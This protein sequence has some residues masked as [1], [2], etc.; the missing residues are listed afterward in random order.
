M[1]GH[2]DIQESEAGL[3]QFGHSKDD[4][5][6]RQIKLYILG[7]RKARISLMGNYACS[8]RLRLAMIAEEAG[9]LAITDD[10]RRILDIEPT[11]LHQRVPLIIGS[12]DE[13]TLAGEYFKK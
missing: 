12:R 13:V 5:N 10:G 3:L 6:L 4:E 9:G 8:M 11:D 1:F 7:I 2:S